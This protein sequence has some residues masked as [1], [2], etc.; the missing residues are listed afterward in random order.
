MACKVAMTGNNHCLILDRIEKNY[1]GR[2]VGL[3]QFIFKHL[4]LNG[5]GDPP[6]YAYA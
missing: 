4:R 5:N 3:A 2:E 1:S 6:E